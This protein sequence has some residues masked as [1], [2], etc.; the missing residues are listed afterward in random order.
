MSK[1]VFLKF[2]SKILGCH[3]IIFITDISKRAEYLNAM[4]LLEI[5]NKRGR[6]D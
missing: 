1:F 2:P 5:T 6:K 3:V 4:L